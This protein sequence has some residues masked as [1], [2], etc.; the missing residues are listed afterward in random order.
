MPENS[1]RPRLTPA[2]ADIRRAVRESLQD[3]VEG[4]LVLVALS[5][6]PDSLALAAGTAFE[7]PRAGLRAGA[8]IIDHGL[9]EGSDRIAERAA[10]QAKALG[11]DPIIVRRVTVGD[12]GGPE[13][14][15]RQARYAELMR[16]R[17][18]TGASAIL[19]GHTLDDQAETVLLGL[20]RGSGA[21][22]L[23]GMH[24]I[25]GPMRRPLLQIRRDSTHS[26]CQD[27]GLEPWSDPHNMD[28]RYTRVRIRQRVLPVL[29][30]ELGGGVALALTR[31]ADQL[32]EDAEALA[33]FAQEQI[34]DLVEHAEA[35][36][37]LEAEA[38]RANPPALRQ[39]I[40]RLAVQSEFHVSLT[41]QQTLEVSRLVT[42]WHGQGPLDLPGLK[43]HREGRRIYFTAA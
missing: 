9:Q 32:R 31:T 27:Q 10:E 35:G 13:A 7:A 18:E 22:S 40:I 4:D 43:V 6:G 28:E 39:R 12:A 24:P 3:L 37:S 15:A 5:G 26:A 1:R 11:L 14:A 41:R 30:E 21:E 17:K 16:V 20:A 8:V 38:L 2:M 42:D 23:W 29:D 33:H 36:L 19:L 25:I 34:G